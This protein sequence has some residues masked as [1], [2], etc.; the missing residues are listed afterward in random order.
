MIQE[1]VMHTEKS[2][3][4]DGYLYD[5]ETPDFYVYRH[6][7]TGKEIHIAKTPP[8]YVNVKD[9]TDEVLDKIDSIK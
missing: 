2:D 6:E 8:L 3:I 5:A 9:Y 4:P 1:I 7:Y